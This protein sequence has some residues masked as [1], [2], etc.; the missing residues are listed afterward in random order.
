MTDFESQDAGKISY[1][2]VEFTDRPAEASHQ[3]IDNKDDLLS[4][5]RETLSQSPS[6]RTMLAEAKKLG[7]TMDIDALEGPD[8]HIDVPQKQIILSDQSLPISALGRS[9]YFKNSL[10]VSMIRALRDVWQ[11]KRHGGFDVDYGPEEVLM[12]ERV[13]AADLDILAVLVAWELRAEGQGSLW[14][15]MIGS[16]DGDLAM[17]FSGYLDRDPSSLFN[18]KALAAA[19]GQWF[20]EE[21]RINAC[22]HEAL[23]Y[24]D[25]LIEDAQGRETFGHKKLSAIAVERLSCLPDRTAYLQ[26]Q[27]R[28]ILADP[29]YAG[30]SDAINQAHF[31][32]IIYDLK[33][34]RVQSV[35]FRSAALAE[36]IFPGGLF[37]PEE[38]SIS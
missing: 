3:Y 26:G 22:D 34:T 29:L 38:E 16:E 18:G 5:T 19:F 28:E 8:F 36:R 14:R 17:R 4:W 32:Q 30:L 37:T 24:M 11:E 15:H 31:M 23:N 10:L 2:P 7:W 21:R 1:E 35:P 9:A 6:A 12:L 33:V 13:R 25:S 20:R 27:G